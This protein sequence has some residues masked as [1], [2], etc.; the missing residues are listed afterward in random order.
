MEV[1]RNLIRWAKDKGVEL[2]GI[3]PQRIPNRG[4]GVVATRNLKAG[5]TILTVPTEA[6]R[7]LDTIPKSIS[8]KLPPDVSLH[9]LL[10]ANLALDDTTKFAPWNA[11]LPTWA[12]FEASTPF[13]WPEELQNLLPKPAKDLLKKQQ[14]KFQ[15][16]WDI[17]TK[18]FLDMQRQEYLYAWFVVNTRTFYYVTPKM[19]TFPH[20]DKLALLPVADLL[21]HADSGCHVSFSPESFTIAADRAYCADEEVYISYG[22]HSNDFLLAEYGF[23]L[24]KNRWDEVC[25]DDVI[26]PKLNTMQK[27]ELE[28]RGFLGKYML[29]VETPGCHRTQVVLRLLCCTLGQWRRFVDAEDDG[30]ASQGEV[31]TLLMQLLDRFLQ[32]IDKTLEDIE[33]LHVGQVTQRELLVTRWKQIQSMI[34]QTIKHLK[35]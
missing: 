13:M 12:D 27:A 8:R 9:A 35:I 32:T 2:N 23:V 7:S 25:L 20:N 10:A 28:D 16:E 4:L 26:L 22:G 30:E 5:E 29:D 1:P 15:R 31:D 14:V 33:N 11:V 21:N 18:T 6:L 3:K 34:T 24:A 17:V 19:E